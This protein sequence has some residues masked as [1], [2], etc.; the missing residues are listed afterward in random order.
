MTTHSTTDRQRKNSRTGNTKRRRTSAATAKLRKK[1]RAL[2]LEPLELRTLLSAD[3][4]EAVL[5][6]P[7]L[8]DGEDDCLEPVADVQQTDKSGPQETILNGSPEAEFPEAYSLCYDYEYVIITN[9]DLK[10]SFQPL[11]EQKQSRGLTGRIVTTEYIYAN[12][13]GTESGDNPDKIRD[14][15][16]YV[17]DDWGT[18]WVLLGGDVEIIPQRGVYAEY[19][20]QLHDDLPTDLYYAC[21][22][23]PWNGDSDGVWGEVHDGAAGGDIDLV[24]EVYIGRAPVSNITETTNF[25]NKTVLYETTAHPNYDT[26]VWLGE[27]IDSNTWGAYSSMEIRD[28][29]LPDNLNLIEHYELDGPW[30]GTQLRDDLNNSPHF[31]NN[32]SHASEIYDSKLSLSTVAALTNPFPYLIYSQGCD[33]GSFDTVDVSIAEQHVVA[34]HGAFAAI[35]NSRDGW[36]IPGSDPGASH[37]FA[38][39]FW[40]AVFNEGKVHLGEANQDAK[41]ENLWRVGVCGYARWVY[42]ET[43]LLGDPETPIQLN[44]LPQ[45]TVNTLLGTVWDD[46]DGDGTQ[47]S[48]SGLANQVVYVDLNENGQ[49]DNQVSTFSATDVPLA[50]PDPGTVTSQLVVSGGPATIQ[51]VNVTLDITHPCNG[52][53]NVFLISPS[54]ARATLFRGVSGV[55]LD[56]TVLDDDAN[57]S[58]FDG[59]S[60]FTG[61]FQPEG[62]L[63]IFEG[64]D[65]N[66]TWTLEITDTAGNYAGTLNSWSLEISCVEPTATTNAQGNYVLPVFASGSVTIRHEL[67]TNWSY[68]TPLSGTHDVTLQGGTTEDVNFGISEHSQPEA[69]DD[70]IQ[71]VEGATST[72]LV[73]GATN[74]LDNDTDLDLPEDTLTVNTTPVTNVSHGTLALNPNGTFSY[75]HDGSENLSDSFVYEVT[76]STGNTDSAT[77]TITVSAVNDAPLLSLP[78]AQNADEDAVL[79][80]TGISVS[81]SDAA[82]DSVQFAMSVAHGR[83]TLAQTNGLTFTEGSG[84]DSAAM[85]FTGTVANVNAALATVNYLGNTNYNGSETLNINVDDLGNSGAGGA[86][87]DSGIVAITVAAVNDTP[88]VTVP[89]AQ[90]ATEDATHSIAGISIAD[91]DAATGSVRVTASVSHGHLTLAQTAGLSFTVGDGASDGSMTFTGTLTNVNAALATVTYAGNTNHFGADTLNIS[92]NDQDNTGSGGAKSDSSTVAITVSGVNDAPVL[93]VPDRQTTSVD[94]SLAI[95][96]IDIQDVDAGS[97]SIQVSVSATRGNLTLATASGLTFTDGDGFSDTAMTMSGTRTAVNAALAT[98]TY[99]PDVGYEGIDTIQLSVSDLGNTGSG[100][101]L[102]H[103]GSILVHVG[104]VAD[105]IAWWTV[106]ETSGSVAADTSPFGAT[107]N[108]PLQGNAQW[109]TMGLNGAVQLDGNGDGVSLPNS[110]DFNLGTTGAER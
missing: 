7:C 95:T 56:S 85:T 32:L 10:S 54:G 75:T 100:G 70:A 59:S 86:K 18:E 68:T 89:G 20:G 1:Q 102:T 29:V 9:N 22:E 39:S 50:I 35:M 42:M 15:I 82:N 105:L 92:V 69:N 76:D 55:N 2:R 25:V 17:H 21:L 65:A 33:A 83:M 34:E 23:G 109:T 72:V 103:S 62:L 37:R 71:L 80:I 11:L 4:L 106:D 26:A 99:D 24:P 14:F 58:I 88:V 13:S 64:E 40:D 63:S 90:L 107:H 81:D 43:N 47:E 6:G 97:G 84:T 66:G 5:G 91:L 110:N 41:L 96:G 27:Q 52:N 28:D 73:G 48:E 8:L 46:V 16:A 98:L 78:A 53:L 30:T 104:V 108:G 93:S 67:P 51:D 94:T 44:G 77:V 74:L 87:T 79:A 57:T 38:F 31:V 3:V 61:T 45:S 36:Y 101:V 60:P 12:F 49:R 19:G